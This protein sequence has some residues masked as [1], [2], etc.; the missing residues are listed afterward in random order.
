VTNGCIGVNVCVGCRLPLLLLPQEQEVLVLPFVLESFDFA[1]GLVQKVPAAKNLGHAGVG[2]GGA[3]CVCGAGGTSG[4]RR[5]CDGTRVAGVGVQRREGMD[6]QR[7]E[8]M[9]ALLEMVLIE[10]VLAL[11]MMI[12]EC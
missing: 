9:N 12:E 11:L 3:V 4:V 7:R 2:V 6:T 10:D 5:D 8:G 1:H